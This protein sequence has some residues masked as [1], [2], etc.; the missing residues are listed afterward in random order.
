MSISFGETTGSF[1]QSRKTAVGPFPDASA[2]GYSRPQVGV[3]DGKLSSAR[4]KI[5]RML[6]TF[7]QANE[8][9]RDELL[10]IGGGEVVLQLF[11]HKT[12]EFDVGWVFYYQSVR[13]IE[14][15][16]LNEM[17]VGGA[18]LF[19]SRSDGRAFFISYHR[20]LEE[21]L[22][23]YRACGDISARE[24]PEVRLTGWRKGALAVSAIQ[25]IR[26]HSRLGLANAKS[27]VES[28]LS[29]QF[30]IVHVPSVVEAK[31]L[32]LSLASVGFDA[33]VCYSLPAANSPE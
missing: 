15:E 14:T 1:G 19:I 20:P 5:H 32:V 18:P 29:N 7:A 4:T 13:F 23:A 12:E 8:I 28:C 17:L 21:S 30:P 2:T 11:P 10:S 22:A 6:I 26:Q 25:A 16:N 24:V 3:R 9:A 27:A 31:A 33:E